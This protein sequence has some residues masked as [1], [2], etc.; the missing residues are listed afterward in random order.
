MQ[1][2]RADI[3]IRKSM[4]GVNMEITENGEIIKSHALLTE[5]PVKFGFANFRLSARP[6]C[7]FCTKSNGAV[8]YLSVMLK[9]MKTAELYMDL[10][11]E[12][13]GYYWKKFRNAGINFQKTRKEKA[14]MIFDVIWLLCS[15]N[16]AETVELP[17]QKGFYVKQDGQLCYAGKSDLIWT[18]VKD[19]AR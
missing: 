11:R 16:I 3:E 13:A 4:L 5:R 7:Y 12:K 19:Y 14:D 1:E 10:N 9:N 2:I 17:P 8:L 15:P 18:E 6:I